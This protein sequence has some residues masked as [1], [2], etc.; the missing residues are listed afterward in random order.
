MEKHT[1]ASGSSGKKIGIEFYSSHT[2]SDLYFLG[3]KVTTHYVDTYEKVTYDFVANLTG[4]EIYVAIGC[5]G[6]TMFGWGYYDG[7]LSD[8]KVSLTYPDTTYLY[9]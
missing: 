5:D 4:N 3:R 9:L 6:Y 8:M 1:K 7:Y 2:M